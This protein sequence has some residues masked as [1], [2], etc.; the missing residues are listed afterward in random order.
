[1]N[2]NIT[3]KEVRSRSGNTARVMVAE[4]TSATEDNV[5]PKGVED[6][7]NCYRNN[8]AA[9]TVIFPGIRKLLGKLSESGKRLGL[10]TSSERVLADYA[11]E[12]SGLGSFF[13]A[14]VG[15]D[16]VQS[17]K[18]DPEGLRRVLALLKASPKESI[19]IGDSPADILAGR[20]AG[21]LTG[22]A[23]WGPEGNGDP[24]VA[25]P[26]FVFQD[27]QQLSKFLLSRHLA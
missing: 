16:E 13:Q 10:V 23:I 9:M 7:Y 12:K 22:A 6:Y 24:I 4:L 2:R 18:P 21:V 11:L 5:T 19:M 8:F 20:Q 1:L 3:Q 14:I 17:P 26:N 27:V 15:G 25:G